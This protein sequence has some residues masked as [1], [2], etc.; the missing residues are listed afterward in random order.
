M[1]AR[2]FITPGPIEHLRLDARP[3]GR[4]SV[5]RGARRHPLA[6]INTTMAGH[7][8][9]LAA[10]VVAARNLDLSAEG[11]E[12]IPAH[13]PVLLAVR[14]YHHFYDGVVL[15]T[16]VPRRVHML[17]T[18]DWVDSSRLRRVMEWATRTA[19]WPTVLRA[20]ALRA[21]ADGLIPHPRS[22]FGLD[23]VERYRMR[24]LRDCVDRLSS[25]SALAVFP[26]GYPNVDPRFTPKRAPGEFL[27]FR[28]GFTT[29]VAL[30]ERRLRHR[31]PI[32][33][34][35]LSFE[36]GTRWR[37]DLRCGA[38]LYLDGSRDALV[39]RVQ[40]RVEMLSA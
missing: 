26:E 9:R 19:G 6:A 38:P 31:V 24:G 28:A 7:S 12:H 2:P 10:R 15:L 18:L 40:Q 29:I 37:V 8:L 3:A 34:V 25:G 33:P 14:H 27:P 21:D 5:G 16:A 39:R 13:G 35:G 17:V 20:E 1:P 11:L 36:A 22:A 23:E 32:V 30:A 4:R